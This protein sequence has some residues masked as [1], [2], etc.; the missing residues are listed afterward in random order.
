[1]VVDRSQSPA[2]EPVNTFA[3]FNGGQN[4]FVNNNQTAD[5]TTGNTGF[6]R[7]RGRGRGNNGFGNQGFGNQGFGNQGFGNTTAAPVSSAPVTVDASVLARLQ[8]R[9]QAESQ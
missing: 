8:A 4:Q 1:M 2:A 3:Q 6:G 9:R 7:G 5:D